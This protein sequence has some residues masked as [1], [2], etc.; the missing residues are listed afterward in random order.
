MRVYSVGKNN[1]TAAGTF[2]VGDS[3]EL[4][5]SVH[6]FYRK[7]KYAELYLSLLQQTA[8][9]SRQSWSVHPNRLSVTCCSSEYVQRGSHPD[10]LVNSSEA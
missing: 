8:T 3:L 1:S 6:G 10:W 9:I 4:R 2:R 7:Q 5:T